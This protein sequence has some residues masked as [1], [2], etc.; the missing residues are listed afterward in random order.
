M[1]RLPPLAKQGL[2][3]PQFERD[4]CG[5]GVV[6]N[7]AGFKSHDIIEKGLEVL[8]NLSHRG[9]RGADPETGDGAGLLLQ[10]PHQLFRR[11]CAKLGISLPEPGQYGVGMVFLPM[12]AAQ[13]KRCEDIF[14]EIVAEEGQTVLGWRDVPVDNSQI[15]S[16]ARQVEPCIRQLFIG[17]AST[18]VDAHLEWKLYVIRKR[19]ER[20]VSESGMQ[21]AE[22]FY[23]PSLSTNRIVYK[24][25]LITEQ[26]ERFYLDLTDTAMESAFT[27]VH[28]RFS[29]NTLGS[30]KLAHPYRFLCHNGE[31][32][33]LRGNINWMTARQAMFSSEEFGDDL[34]KLFPII[35]SRGQS[36]TA[37][38][39]NALELLLH[40]GRSLPHSLMM[41]VPEAW[42][43]TTALPQD[44]RDFYEYHSSMMEPWD[45]PALLACTDGSDVAIILDRNGL[46]PFRYLVTKDQLLVMASEV[47]VLDVAPEDVVYKGRIQPGRMFLVDTA[48][49]R[50]VDDEEIKAEMAGRRPYGEWLAQNRVVLDD[51]PE[52]PSVSE[53]DMETLSTRQRAFGVTQEDLDLL[54]EPMATAS[55]EAEGS[56]GTD[57]PLAVLSDRPQLLFGYFKQLFAQV[58]NPPLDAIR[59]ELVTSLESTI[60]SEQNLFE[61]TPR[62][63]H[64]L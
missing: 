46:R 29:T 27:L 31:I 16:G 51:L 44:K 47:G 56:M 6:A 28:S 8:V 20:A 43:E 9:A 41:L 59:E 53:P 13:R 22:S 2:Y 12:E 42:S 35:P 5:V 62:H 40:T 30:W 50:I 3:D 57:T 48:E 19:V 7:I 23:V 55:K 14:E 58:S 45:G 37:S 64:Q 11:E 18:I 10:M 26:L 38:I 34:E 1:N 21:D 36:D 63:C 25:L 32:N 33:T 49:G 52:P 4:A 24:G 17:S 15:G 61:E 60:G 54:M 39:D